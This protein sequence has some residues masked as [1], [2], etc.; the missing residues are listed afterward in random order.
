MKDQDQKSS[1][2]FRDSIGTIDE[3]G[4]RSWIYAQKPAGS[5]YNKRTLLSIAY[6]IV[7]FVGWIAMHFI[8]IIYDICFLACT[9]SSILINI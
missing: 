3:E 1:E 6:L 2:S 8:F 7:F 9:I 4:K 5:L